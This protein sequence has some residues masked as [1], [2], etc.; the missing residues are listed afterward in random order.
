VASILKILII[1]L[2]VSCNAVSKKKMAPF[3]IVVVHDCQ[4]VPSLKQGD[5][6]QVRFSQYP[7]KGYSWA[8]KQPL[9]TNNGIIFLGKINIEPELERDDSKQ[10][11]QFS[12][13]MTKVVVTN[14]SFE[15]RR[16]WE[17]TSPPAETCNLQLKIH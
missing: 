5:T 2:S 16:P 3:R 1:L 6:L 11:V 9:E 15:Y 10:T 4:K 8:L 7:G 14:L 17:K 12:F 13:L